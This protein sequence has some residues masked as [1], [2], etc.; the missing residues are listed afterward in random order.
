MRF[1]LLIIVLIFETFCVYTQELSREKRQL[2]LSQ[3]WRD[4]SDNYYN[5]LFLKKINWDSIYIEYSKKNED[6]KS[7]LDYCRLLRAFLAEVQDGHTELCGWEYVE[8]Q[9][10]TV[11][12]LPFGVEWIGNKLYITHVIEDL[13][14][15]L[16]LCSEILSI[17]K[18]SPEMYYMRNIFP[19]CSASTI[20]YKRNR[21]QMLSGLKGDS[22]DLV[23]SKAGKKDTLSLVYD[24]LQNVNNN[25]TEMNWLHVYPINEQF[26][27][28]KSQSEEGG[29]YFLRFDSFG[30][31]KNIAQIMNAAKVKIENSDY[32]ILDLRYNRGGDEMKADSLLMYFNVLDTLRTYKSI[33]RVHNAFKAAMGLSYNSFRK[34][35]ENL[36]VDTLLEDC[37]VNNGAIYYINKPLY[38]LIS[39]RTCSAAEDFLITLK[40]RKF[41][42]V[43]LVGMP[44]A[45]TT[46]AP[47][48]RYLS[49][50]LYYRICT[51]WPLLQDGIFDNGIQPDFYY[52]P[53]I[54]EL[55][56]G[57]DRIL[58][59]V[60]QL[61]EQKKYNYEK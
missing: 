34:Y 54:E 53:K 49:N 20:Q 61:Y 19:Y 14:E 52:E 32:V 6:V 60:N 46:G 24:L 5:P 21:V 26:S 58:E 37:Y 57:K 51:R 39:N 45:G 13:K 22:I 35:Y 50:N 11:D 40:L 36:S 12:Y 10:M 41:K 7:E 33:T 4:V 55:A 2:V 16:P 17:D 43:T 29:F 38:V 30:E 27:S 1:A 8:R 48:V 25:K 31:D 59:F 3:V 9:D 44:T 18:Q 42:N 56:L 15:K 47:L 28:W 23:L